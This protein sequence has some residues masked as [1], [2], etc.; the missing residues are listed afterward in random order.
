MLRYAS[1]LLF[2]LLTVITVLVVLQS[3]VVGRQFQSNARNT[4]G[5][6]TGV[7]N[8]GNQTAIGNPI[9]ILPARPG[10]LHTPPLP[11]QG[12]LARVQPPEIPAPAMAL[13]GFKPP[14]TAVAAE[15]LPAEPQTAEAAPAASAP[16]AQP[17][18]QVGEIVLVERV[19]PKFPA[20]AAR[21]GITSG[22]VTV[23][24]TVQPDGTVTD[25]SVIAA[26]PRRG[27]FDDAAM[28]AVLKWK[29]K[30]IPEPRDTSVII[31]FSQDSGG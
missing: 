24:F 20:Q 15:A 11:E 18:L 8:L 13:P 16:Q 21:E 23:K 1:S 19:E 4:G 17:V 26:K 9:N 3:F 30:P 7:V 29:F 31:S 10:T 25:T 2:G 22:E 5:D 6:D 27:V 12:G 14:F 28:R